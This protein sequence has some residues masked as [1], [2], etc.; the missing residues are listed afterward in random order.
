MPPSPLNL[1]P[2]TLGTPFPEVRAAIAAF[3]AETL[4]WPLQA[5]VRGREE[6][7]AARRLAEVLWGAPV[8]I[9]QGTTQSLNLILLAM[10]RQFRRTATVLTSGHEHEGGIGGFEHHPDFKVSY[11]PDSHLG[12]PTRFSEYLTKEMPDILFLSQVTW[13]D[14]RRLPVE[15]LLPIARQLCPESWIIL[16]A[17]QVVGLS[18]PVL[19]LADMTV[20]SGHK[21]LNGPAGTGFLWLGD[22]AQQVLKGLYWMGH[23]LDPSSTMGAFEPAG[24]QD[25]ARWAGLHAALQ[26]YATQG[27]AARQAHSEQLARELARGLSTILCHYGVAHDFADG[28]GG[29]EAVPTL[30]PTGVCVLRFSEVDPYPIYHR[31]NQRGLHTKCIKGRGPAGQVFNQLRWGVPW[32]EISDRVQEALM[33]FEEVLHGH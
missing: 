32:F 2:G 6:L 9:A 27:L 8:A 1:N 23:P 20:A 11:L 12:D 3:E 16:D 31:M 4:G 26:V 29:W 5:Y 17:A 30:G 21:W 33:C 25:F 15:L 24:G 13:T 14:A 22:R 18:Q 7:A 19:G 28:L 10:A